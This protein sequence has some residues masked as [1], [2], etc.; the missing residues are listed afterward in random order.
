MVELRKMER[1]EIYWTLFGAVLCLYGIAC[2]N[3]ANLMLARLIGKRREVSV[4]L[5]LGGG[6]W[7]VIRLFII[8]GVSLS[9]AG[10]A[11]GA[12]VANWMIPLFWELTD[13]RAPGVGWSDWSLNWRIFSFLVGTTMVTALATA[14]TNVTAEL[15]QRSALNNSPVMQAALVV[16]RMQAALDAQRASIQEENLAAVRLLLAESCPDGAT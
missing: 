13:S 3:V 2:T 16:H 5:S 7:R 9:L 14:L 15:T 12:L 6:N 4:R 10:C 8:E 1:P 11:F